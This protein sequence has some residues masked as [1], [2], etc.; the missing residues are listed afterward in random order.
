MRRFFFWE[1]GGGTFICIPKVGVGST[2]K[3]TLR[4]A[5]GRVVGDGGFG[6]GPWTTFS[7]EQCQMTD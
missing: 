6:L 7:Q 5:C 2:K 4:L 1:G 3:H